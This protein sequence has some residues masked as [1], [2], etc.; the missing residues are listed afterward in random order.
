MLLSPPRLRDSIAFA[1]HLWTGSYNRGRRVRVTVPRASHNGRR[2]NDQSRWLIAL[3]AVLFWSCIFAAIQVN[4]ALK[5][6]TTAS[7]D[8]NPETPLLSD[9]VA[10]EIRMESVRTG[11]EALELAAR[12]T[13]NSGLI[14]RPIAWILRDGAGEIVLRSTAAAAGTLAAPGEY[15]V[16]AT[17]GAVRLK[18]KVNLPA[19]HRLSVVFTLNVGGIRVLPRL[20]GIGL[21]ATPSF[22]TI[23]ATS[24]TA[25]GQLVGVSEMPGEIIRVGSG[26]YRIESRFSPGNVIAVTEVVVKPGKMSAVEIDHRAGV[27]HLV[28]QPAKQAVSWT[29]TDEAG[30]EM[31]PIPGA[32]ADVVLKPGRYTARA[33]IGDATLTESFSIAAGESRSIV[34]RK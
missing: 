28:L 26:S 27:A 18:R 15:E 14:Q 3:A 10:H 12:L 5:A 23:Y 20:A 6:A 31:P 33:S 19:G 25:A 29:I 17:Y 16:E 22:T 34:L 13:E 30:A 4:S 32:S 7:I 21:P 2:R 9:N 8:R 1:G 11:A 24:G